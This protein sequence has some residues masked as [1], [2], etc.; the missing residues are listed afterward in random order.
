MKWEKL[1][2]N[3][4][5]DLAKFIAKFNE[6]ELSFQK[7]KKSSRPPSSS[8][9]MTDCCYFCH[10][11]PSFSHSRSF[12]DGRS[13]HLA[14]S[15]QSYFQGCLP[16]TKSDGSFLFYD[17]CQA[18]GTRYPISFI[19]PTPNQFPRHLQTTSQSPA[20]SIANRQL[21]T[22]SRQQTFI[23]HL[24]SPL[25]CYSRVFHSFSPPRARFLSQLR[26][27]G[28]FCRRC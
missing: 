10:F 4:R 14:V 23:K 28:H 20:T 24:V 7:K 22:R 16:K 26:L 15:C 12:H 18:P 11:F 21:S 17:S 3:C 5:K 2:V 13:F 6:K 25:Q 1:V 19:H 8:I 9:I 27:A